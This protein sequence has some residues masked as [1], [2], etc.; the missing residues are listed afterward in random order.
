MKCFKCKKQ[1]DLQNKKIGFKDYCDYCDF[2][3]HICKNCKNYSI[4]KPNDCYIPNIDIVLDK[5]KNN[6]CEYFEPNNQIKEKKS[7]KKDIEKKLFSNSDDEDDNI[8]F[9]SLFK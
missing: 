8:D 5:E 1:I 7:S 9:D 4:G 3:L 6:F 2:D